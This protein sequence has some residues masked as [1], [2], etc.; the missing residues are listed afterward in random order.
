MIKGKES[1]K[2]PKPGHSLGSTHPISVHLFVFGLRRGTAAS[3]VV[4]TL[5]TQTSKYSNAHLFRSLGGLCVGVSSMT[6]F[7]E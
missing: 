6:C 4:Q 3:T 5:R 7:K 1:V 2:L